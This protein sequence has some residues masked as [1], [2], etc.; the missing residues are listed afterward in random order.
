MGTSP[1]VCWRVEIASQGG[2]FISIVL[3]AILF[4]DLEGVGCGVLQ[5]IRGGV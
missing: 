1:C 2:I 3:R 4:F 5:D